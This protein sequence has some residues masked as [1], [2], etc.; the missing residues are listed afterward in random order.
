LRCAAFES[1]AA[2]D[3]ARIAERVHVC[4]GE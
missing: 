2:A 3:V 4:T 1:V